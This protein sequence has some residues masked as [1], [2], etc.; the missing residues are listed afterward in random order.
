VSG[1]SFERVLMNLPVLGGI[2]TDP[3]GTSAKIRSGNRRYGR[4]FPPP[5]GRYYYRISPLTEA[6]K[7]AASFRPAPAFEDV[8]EPIGFELPLDENGN[9]RKVSVIAEDE[10]Y[11][12]VNETSY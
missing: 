6:R 10:P 3:R 9:V 8:I 12:L 4:Y 2:L 11:T 7:R 5:D 1:L